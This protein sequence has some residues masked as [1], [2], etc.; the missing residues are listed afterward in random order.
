MARFCGTA[1][2][3][4]HGRACPSSEAYKETRPVATS[5]ARSPFPGGTRSVASVSWGR[6]ELGSVPHFTDTRRP[7]RGFAA[8]SRTRSAWAQ[9]AGRRARV[10]FPPGSYEISS[11]PFDATDP[12]RS[13]WTC[14]PIWIR[15]RSVWCPCILSGLRSHPPGLGYHPPPDPPA[16]FPFACLADRLSDAARKESLT[17]FPA[18][19]A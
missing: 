12:A 4:G 3:R 15:L 7:C 11:I 5:L 13:V 17:T 9:F 16:D 14:H 18:A 10:G 6:G 2:P 8:Q 1:A 19:R